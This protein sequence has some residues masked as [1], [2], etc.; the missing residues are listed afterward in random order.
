ME[1]AAGSVDFAG[2]AKIAHPL[3][4]IPHRSLANI[5]HHNPLF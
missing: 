5:Q 1:P 2:F 4:I 3:A